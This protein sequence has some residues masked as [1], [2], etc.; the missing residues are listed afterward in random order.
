MRDGGTEKKEKVAKTKPM[1]LAE[2]TDFVEWTK[3]QRK[4]TPDD[5]GE[6]PPEPPQDTPKPRE[7][8]AKEKEEK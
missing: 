7:S 6:A 5:K 1:P 2:L 3:K 8:G 4:P